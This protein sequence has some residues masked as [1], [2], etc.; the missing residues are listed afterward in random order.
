[1]KTESK[2]DLEQLSQYVAV[3]PDDNG[4]R[5]S[6]AKKLYMAWEYN[7]ALKHLL[8]LKKNWNKK[9][10]VLRY[11]AA[12]YYRLGLY[13]EAIAELHAITLVWPNEIAVWEQLARV[14]EV[15]GRAA[16]AAH[17]WEQVV[18][19]NPAHPTAARSVQRLR[20]PS[21]DVKREDLRL[22]DS[23]SGIDLSPYRICK[24]CGAQNSDEFDR[25]WQCHAVLRDDEPA[26]DSMH[27]VRSPKSRAWLLTLVGGMATVAAATAGMYI[28]LMVMR[29]V[30][31]DVPT[32]FGPVYDLLARQLFAARLVCAGSLLLAW[33]IGLWIGFRAAGV[34]NVSWSR[35]IGPGVLLSSFTY[36]AMWMLAPWLPYAPLIPA[37]LS[38]IVILS[39]GAARIP[40]S[41]EAWIVQGAFVAAVGLGSFGAVSGLQPIV[42]LQAI[43]S[44]SAVMRSLP[45]RYR[46]P[47]MSGVKEGTCSVRWLTTGS[48]W[49]DRHGR[50]V[51]IE[52]QSEK[53][54]LAI[55]L[56]LQ[57]EGVSVSQPAPIPNAIVATVNTDTYYQLNVVAGENEGFTVRSRSVLQAV[58]FQADLL[59]E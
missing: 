4:R 16:E 10:N 7:D 31:R 59:K 11:L 21:T 5:W 27:A 46:I 34:R 32:G 9:L 55:A 6:L 14:Y 38:L 58:P 19:I 52:A 23:D 17:T 8:I 56:D 36:L 49:L 44:H 20:S 41:I 29:Q 2:S 48:S 22:R 25:C 33:P 15:A 26:I 54:D 37:V 24:S 28:S 42:E 12:T 18:R 13:D 57:I 3:N 53:P 43:V 35:L 50:N 39:F 47:V 1:M 30:G 51:I 45:D 40:Q